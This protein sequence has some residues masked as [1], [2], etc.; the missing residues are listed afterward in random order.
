MIMVTEASIHLPLNQNI[1]FIMQQIQSA[2]QIS[3][4]IDII[5]KSVGVTPELSKISES[6]TLLVIFCAR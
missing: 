5:L 3:L 1:C 4:K 6:K 2:N